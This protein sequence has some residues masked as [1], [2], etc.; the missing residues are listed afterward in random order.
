MSLRLLN[1]NIL[2]PLRG[3]RLPTKRKYWRN[4]PEISEVYIGMADQGEGAAAPIQLRLLEPD[5]CYDAR[6]T[7]TNADSKVNGKGE[8]EPASRIVPFKT[9]PILTPEIPKGGTTEALGW[10]I[11]QVGEVSDEG[12]VA[13]AKIET[14]GAETEYAFEY[15]FPE[16]GHA[17]SETSKSWTPFSSDATGKITA[18]ED[19]G[20]VSASVTG[21]LAETTYYVR[22]KLT[23][24]GRYCL[25]D[26]VS[27]WWCGGTRNV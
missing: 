16:N 3:G 5:T 10:P 13:S 27:C 12:A 22:I 9:L 7:A 25:S 11:F 4:Q 2:F 19:Y 26:E 14:N 18:I 15:S 21:L 23:E 6:F 1:A 20:K 24:Q 17:P 8:L